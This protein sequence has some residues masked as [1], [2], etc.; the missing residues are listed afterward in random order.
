MERE[1][2]CSSESNHSL[3]FNYERNA[4]S[5]FFFRNAREMPF[6][7][8]VHEKFSGQHAG[9]QPCLYFTVLFNMTNYTVPISIIY[10]KPGT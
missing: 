3:F 6:L 10:V 4:F 2:M 5:L 8:L 7:N 9:F 1:E